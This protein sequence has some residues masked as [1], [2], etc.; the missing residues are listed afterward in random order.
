MRI[1]RWH[2]K[3]PLPEM[4]AVGDFKFDVCPPQELKEGDMTSELFD[5]IVK[6]VR[7]SGM[8]WSLTEVSERHITGGSTYPYE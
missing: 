2:L 5:A 8:T 1:L 7:Q 4:K 6:A 3:V